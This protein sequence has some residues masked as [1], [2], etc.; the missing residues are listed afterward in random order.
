MIFLASVASLLSLPFELI[1]YSSKPSKINEQSIKAELEE[2]FKNLDQQLL[3]IDEDWDTFGDL[4]DHWTAWVEKLTAE[5][6]LTQDVLLQF[7]GL[8]KQSRDGDAASSPAPSMLDFRANVKYNK[9]KEYH[10]LTSEES[11]RYYILLYSSLSKE[12]EDKALKV[13]LGEEEAEES[14]LTAMNSISVPVV[15]NKARQEYIDSM[16]ENNQQ[17]FKQFE[18]IRENGEESLINMIEKN[19]L[20]PNTENNEGFTVFMLATDEGYSLEW[21][22]KLI[23][24]GAN[25]NHQDQNGNS[26]LHYAAMVDN[27]EICQFLLD[28][29]ADRSIKNNDGL[30]AEEWTEDDE[31]KILFQ[32]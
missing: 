15:D 29:K 6:K 5:N 28:N 17:I 24:L 18:E 1:S 13:L 7:Y 20:T 32:S 22:N 16:N 3:S 21:L 11:Q 27:V 2:R 8:F 9:W 23:T 25:I 14:A 19:E 12:N 4:Y 30:I 31:V 10:G 26:A